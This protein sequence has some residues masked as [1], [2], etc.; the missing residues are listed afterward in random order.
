MK[1]TERIITILFITVVGL[2]FFAQNIIVP[3]F[4]D[5]LWWV[6]GRNRPLLETQFQF[7]MTQNGRIIPHTMLQLC[8]QSGEIAYDI[9]ITLSLLVAVWSLC[10]YGFG[11]VTF[12]SSAIVVLVFLYLVP[13]QQTLFFWAAGGCNYLF[14]L[15]LIIPTLIVIQKSINEEPDYTSWQTVGLSVLTLAAGWT[16]E[17]YALPI[18]LALFVEVIRRRG[19]LKCETWM[20]ICM[21][22]VGALLIVLSPGTWHR[23]V[24]SQGGD[25]NITSKILTSLK[26]FR[27]GRLFYVLLILL[28]GLVLSRRYSIR[29]FFRK[30]LFLFICF[31][32]SLCIVTALGVGGRAIWGVEVFA[33]LLIL[34]WMQ[35]NVKSDSRF[36]NIAGSAVLV[37]MLC[38]QIA[39]VPAFRKSWGTYKQMAEKARS[40][41][42]DFRCVPMEDWQS[43]N[44]LIDPFVA[45]PYKMMRDDVWARLPL[46]CNV[47]KPEEYATLEAGLKSSGP[48]PVGDDFYAQY[49]DSLKDDIENGRLICILRPFDDFSPDGGMLYKAW[50]KTIQKAFPSRYP[51]RITVSRE[52][53]TLMRVGNKLYVRFE[54]PVRPVQRQI[55]TIRRL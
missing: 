29:D 52:N 55:E 13:E 36:L 33:L 27:Y 11:K 16:H 42:A 32:G 50:H 43:G 40:V 46:G 49:S 19:K 18:S 14:P 1:R 9:V 7:W 4:S 48:M 45:H 39:L 37:L 44:V 23:I 20:M 12:V 47:C 10:R 5:D 15:A 17:I 53:T 38:H 24:T 2:A 25:V 3:F 30:Q 54:R 6:A 21:F 31:I 41:K 35:M 34:R 8:T 22:W 51:T 28:I 26:V